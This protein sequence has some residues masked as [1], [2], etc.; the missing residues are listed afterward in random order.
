MEDKVKIVGEPKLYDIRGN[1]LHLEDKVAIPTNSTT[2]NLGVIV[3]LGKVRVKVRYKWT[4][5][6]GQ[7]YLK[8][9]FIDAKQCMKYE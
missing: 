8:E 2:M 5:W 9:R 6:G 4:A 7:E 3:S 1:R